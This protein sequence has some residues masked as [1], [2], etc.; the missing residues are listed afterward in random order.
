MP[1][2]PALSP[3]AELGVQKKGQ[4][5]AG[6]RCVQRG[7]PEYPDTPAE[8]ADAALGPG[9]WRNKIISLL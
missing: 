7:P 3:A 5:G 4:L 2:A 6:K 9:L 1:R 8:V